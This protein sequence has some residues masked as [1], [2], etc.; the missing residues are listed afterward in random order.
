MIV[1]ELEEK[2]RLS[3]SPQLGDDFHQAI[4]PAVDEALYIDG[5]RN[6]FHRISYCEFL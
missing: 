2:I 3:S 5:A 4:L 1:V 6:L